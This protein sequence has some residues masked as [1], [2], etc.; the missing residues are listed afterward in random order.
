MPFRDRM[1]VVANVFGVLFGP[2]YYLT[3]GMWKKAIVL[4]VLSIVVVVA[5]DM[6]LDAMGI[7]DFMGLNFIASAIFGTRA[8]IDYYKKMVLNDN[9][10]W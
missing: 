7:H 5:A 4:T 2:F 9:G 1:N 6:V 10:W 8:N 3:K